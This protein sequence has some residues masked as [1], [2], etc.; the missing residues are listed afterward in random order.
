MQRLFSD[1][2]FMDF[3]I[4][5]EDGEILCHRCVLASCDIEYFKTYFSTM[6]G[7]DSNQLELD[8]S[9]RQVR[10]L[11]KFAYEDY[12]DLCFKIALTTPKSFYD[13]FID[14]YTIIDRFRC[15]E[16]SKKFN[17]LLSCSYYHEVNKSIRQ[18]YID[19]CVKEKIL[20]IIYIQD[21][22]IFRKMVYDDNVDLTKFV[23]LIKNKSDWREHANNLIADKRCTI[24]IF[25]AFYNFGIYENNMIDAFVKGYIDEITFAAIMLIANNDLE[26]SH[27]EILSNKDDDSKMKVLYYIQIKYITCDDMNR[28][29]FELVWPFDLSH[30]KLLTD[31]H[32]CDTSGKRID[33]KPDDFVP[34]AENK[35]Y[36]LIGCLLGTKMN[37]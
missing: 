17:N 2:R 35:D 4:K 32:V 34:S 31:I 13:N 33:M 10:Y 22:D 15:I 1:E 14:Y 5:C 8:L 3:K 26:V 6:I 16:A 9:I 25:K 24:K 19:I 27:Y 37:K 29:E 21:N 23:S 20:P 7:K 12:L 18:Q 28:C 36:A 30:D 11:I